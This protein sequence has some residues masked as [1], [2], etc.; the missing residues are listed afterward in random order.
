MRAAPLWILAA[1]LLLPAAGTT[2]LP[3]EAPLVIADFEG[4]AI[5]TDADDT[6]SRAVADYD[7]FRALAM[8]PAGAAAADI[9]RQAR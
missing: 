3:E 2:A 9:A 1:L 4:I 7:D 8:P 6:G 5:L